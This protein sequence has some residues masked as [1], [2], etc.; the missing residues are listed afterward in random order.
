MAPEDKILWFC[1][2]FIAFHLLSHC[3]FPTFTYCHNS[4]NNLFTG[5]K[6]D[7]QTPFHEHRFLGQQ[8]TVKSVQTS[9]F[10]RSLMNLIGALLLQCEY[11]QTSRVNS[12]FRGTFILKRHPMQWWEEQ[13]QKNP[14][15][16]KKVN[17]F[18]V[19]FLKFLWWN[20]YGIMLSLTNLRLFMERFYYGYGE[21]VW[22]PFKS[23]KHVWPRPSQLSSLSLLNLKL[24]L[25]YSDFPDTFKSFISII[26]LW[27]LCS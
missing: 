22:S 25:F 21:T 12:V 1:R 8:A 14:N 15:I 27:L 2:G 7:R 19:S 26:H 16:L 24:Y 13:Q 4:F 17:K 10:L 3:H 5:R 9:N 23:P 6:I 20:M 11:S 18:I